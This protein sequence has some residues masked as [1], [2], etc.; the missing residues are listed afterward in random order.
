[1]TRQG[2]NEFHGDLNFFYQSDGLTS[3]NSDGLVNP[4]GSF[5][6]ACGRRGRCPWTRDKYNDFTAQLGGPIVKDK[7]WFFA[8]YQYQRDSQSDIG[9]ATDNPL[10]FKRVL[11]RPLLR[12]AELADQ[13]GPQAGRH[14]P[15]GREEHG[16]R[17]RH[18]RG[19]D[20]TAWTRRSKTPTPGLAYTGVLSDKTVLEVRYSGFY[21]DVE[22]RPHRPR[23]AARPAPLL[24]PRHLFISGGH[25]YWYETEPRRTT[26]TAKISHLADNFL[27]ASH[28]FKFGVQYSDA[29]A[30]G[31]YGYNDLVFTYTLRR[32]AVRLRLRAAA[33]Q[34][35]RQQPQPGR[36]PG[37][38]RPRERPALAQPRRALRPQQGVLRRAGRARRV[39]AA[40]PAPPSRGPTST[41][42]RTGRRAWAS[43]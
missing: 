40:R 7:L 1:M 11:R 41:P 32:R 6:N 28:D 13:P 33:L 30:R 23:P 4:D 38:H 22:R 27:G 10:A 15:P 19:A 26:V 21:G 16:Q 5:V 2:T 8:S 35:Q 39:R 25:Y 12:Q 29:V 31:L 34:L 37:R 42:G 17:H 14:L 20:S 9:V 36:V 24:R 18:R 3:N 43:T